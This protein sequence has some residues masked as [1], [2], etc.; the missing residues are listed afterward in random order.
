MRQSEWAPVRTFES[1]TAYSQGNQATAEFEELA[2]SMVNRTSRPFGA[3]RRFRP[4][5]TSEPGFSES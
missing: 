3:S 2:M 5:Q 4:A 1:G